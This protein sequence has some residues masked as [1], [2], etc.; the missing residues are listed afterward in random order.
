MFDDISYYADPEYFRINAAPLTGAF[1]KRE[2]VKFHKFL[3]S[4]TQGTK[5]WKWIDNSKGGSG[6][7][8]ALR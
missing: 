3:K 8:K 7:M 6:A 1:F 5:A 2:N 4:I